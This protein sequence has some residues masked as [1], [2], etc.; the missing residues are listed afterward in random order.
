MNTSSREEKL[1]KI[2][3]TEKIL[4]D[5]QDID[6]LLEQLLTEARSIVN[7]DAGSIYV[8]DEDTK[9]LSIK[10]SQNDTQQKLLEPGQKLPYSFFSFP[11]NEKSISG[12]C[13]LNKEILNI[14]DVYQ[15]PEDSIYKFN[16]QPDLLSGYQT[17]SMLTIPLITADGR[18]LGV[19]QIINAQDE[20][21]NFIAFDKDAE[22]YIQHFA[23]NATAALERT[24]LTRAMVLRMARMAEMRDPKETGTHVTRVSRYSVEIY[25][26][27]AFNHNIPAKEKSTY[28]DSLAIAAMLHDVG[29]VGISD[30]VLKKPGRFDDKERNIIKSHTYICHFLFKGF[31]SGL[32]KMTLDVALHHHERWDGKGYPGNVDVNKITS[33]DVILD[34]YESQGLSGNEIPLSAR[35]VAIA[36]V[37]DALSHKRCYKDAWNEED[38]LNELKKQSG[39][40]F[41]PELIDVFFDVYPTIKE[42]QKSLPDEE[43]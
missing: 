26:R 32:D 27:W 20:Q 18:I 33:P 34:L 19:L 25:D 14:P 24:Y 35:I 8:W 36:D 13:V 16:R 1:Q 23:E 15:I 5:I 30:L 37:F 43:S 4:N 21:G 10:Y 40:Q 39:A 3:E 28:R 11:A 29:K 6:V 42:I 17:K 7:A 38:V 41:D 9:L 31:I 22:L 12:Y 2:I